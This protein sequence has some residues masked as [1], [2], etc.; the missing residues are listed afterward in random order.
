MLTC[1]ECFAKMFYRE[2]EQRWVCPKC[3]VIVNDPDLGE[4]PDL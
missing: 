1:P 3:G 2:N 4:M